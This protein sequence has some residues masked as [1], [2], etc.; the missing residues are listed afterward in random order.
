MIW[1]KRWKGIKREKKNK[2]S[3]KKL[4]MPVTY[5]FYLHPYKH[6]LIDSENDRV[7]PE[8]KQIIRTRKRES[9]TSIQKLTH[10]LAYNSLQSKRLSRLNQEKQLFQKVR[11]FISDHIKIEDIPIENKLSKTIQISQQTIKLSQKL[12]ISIF[13]LQV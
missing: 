1:E 6:V 12:T 4:A 9:L 2:N 13:T 7:M 3:E 10:S 5:Y 8:I 11:W